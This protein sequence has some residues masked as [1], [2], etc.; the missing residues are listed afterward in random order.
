VKD[1]QVSGVHLFILHEDGLRTLDITDPTK[2]VELSYFQA[3][4]PL[5]T[6]QTTPFA[7]MAVASDARL[8]DPLSLYILTSAG[9]LCVLDLT[10]RAAPQLIKAM[11]VGSVQGLRVSGKY[12]YLLGEYHSITIHDFSDP[13]SPRLV[14]YCDTCARSADA[15]FFVPSDEYIHVR[16]VGGWLIYE[17]FDYGAFLPMIQRP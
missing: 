7:G 14:A 17:V 11:P 5:T 1:V 3:R 2:P 4:C 15:L 8:D 16:G 6:G 13:T 10:N 9:Y 12:V